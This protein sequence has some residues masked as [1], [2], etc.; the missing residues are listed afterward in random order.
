[1]LQNT[2]ASRYDW[3]VPARLRARVCGAGERNV[4][5]PR[6]GNTLSGAVIPEIVKFTL[7]D[8]PVLGKRQYEDRVLISKSGEVALQ[9][10]GT[11][12]HTSCSAGATECPP[13]RCGASGGG[14][15]LRNGVCRSEAASAGWTASKRA[16]PPG[17]DA[18]TGRGFRLE[19]VRRSR[20]VA[21]R[22]CVTTKAKQF[23]LLLFPLP[24]LGART[25]C[26][27]IYR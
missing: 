25:T 8:A 27:P 19:P 9:T 2:V 6:S 16:I 10:V 24:R 21:R 14:N 22:C 13:L 5:N 4:A 7:F 20:A 1:M 3:T 23:R 18:E 26:P 11:G 17:W 12:V 15:R